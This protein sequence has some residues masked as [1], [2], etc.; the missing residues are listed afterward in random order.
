M[1]LGILGWSYRRT[2]I[3]LRD[4]IALSP[5]QQKEVTPNLCRE[6]QLQEIM[7]LSTCNRTEIYFVAENCEKSVQDLQSYLIRFW[8]E[9]ELAQLGYTLFDLDA[10]RHIFRVAASLD[11]MI[12]G[13]S[14]ILGQLKEAHQ[15]FQNTTTARITSQSLVAKSIFYRKTDSYRNHDCQSCCVGKLCRG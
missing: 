9:A 12:L 14:Q 15:R 3:E 10:V 5:L 8:N 7:I 1:K 2:P 6:A 4:R 13:E 11:S